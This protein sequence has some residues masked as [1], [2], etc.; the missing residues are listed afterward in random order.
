MITTEPL[1]DITQPPLTRLVYCSK[2]W[3]WQPYKNLLSVTIINSPWMC[4]KDWF[5]HFKNIMLE[6]LKMLK[7]IKITYRYIKDTLCIPMVELWRKLLSQW[8][9]L[10]TFQVNMRNKQT[11]SSYNILCKYININLVTLYSINK[12]NF[13]IVMLWPTFQEK[14]LE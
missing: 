10:H 1:Q 7:V 12:N 2:I 5:Y 9:F 6:W 8:N 11:S 3:R 13:L 4:G 14:G